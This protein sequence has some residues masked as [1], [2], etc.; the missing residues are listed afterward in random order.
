[1]LTFK[2]ML[3]FTALLLVPVIIAFRNVLRQQ[4]SMFL[5]MMLGYTGCYFM[6][7]FY[8]LLNRAVNGIEHDGLEMDWVAML[9]TISFLIA[10]WLCLHRLPEEGQNQ[11]AGFKRKLQVC[12]LVGIVAVIAESFAGAAG[13]R[14]LFIVCY[15]LSVIC[16]YT[17][18]VMTGIRVKSAG[19][20]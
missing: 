7:N 12:L 11:M 17:I 1:M 15:A 2:T 18:T 8:A 4:G 10:T 9:A 19:K 14:I 6:K 5:Q 20:F 16:I 3:L 13:N